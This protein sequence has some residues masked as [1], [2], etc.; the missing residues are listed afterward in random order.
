MPVIRF[1]S[2]PTDVGDPGVAARRMVSAAVGANTITCGVSVFEPGS[3]IFLHTHPCEE[4]VAIV[5]GEAVC[6]LDGERHTLRPFDLSF[7]PP[8][9]PHRFVNESDAPFT[10]IYFYP[11]TELSRD[12]VAPDEMPSQDNGS[13]GR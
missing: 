6:E 13:P 4:V 5:A 8:G 3:G 7:V 10:M 11:T 9:V 12:P 1:G 2:F